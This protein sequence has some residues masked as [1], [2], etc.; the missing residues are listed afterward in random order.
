MLYTCLACAVGFQVPEGQRE[1]Y[2]T[3]WHRY[4]LKRKVAELPAVSAEVFAQK[5]LQQQ[6][7]ARRDK[8]RETLQCECRVCDKVY[9]SHNAYVNHLQSKRH[10]LAELQKHGD[11]DRDSPA[12]S[13]MT[14]STTTQF[15]LGDPLVAGGTQHHDFV[16]M[17][18]LEERV[19]EGRGEGDA[20]SEALEEADIEAEIERRLRET[21]RFEQNECIFC[22]KVHES[23]E[24]DVQ[25]MYKAHGMFIPEQAYLVDLAGL[26]AYLGAKVAVGHTCLFCNRQFKTLLLVRRHMHNKGHCMIKY[27]NEESMLEIG[28]FYDFRSTYPKS[29][30]SN[31]SEWEDDDDDDDDD[32]ESIDSQDLGPIQMDSTSMYLP[33][34]SKTVGHRS[35]LRYYRQTL[36]PP[37]TLPQGFITHQRLMPDDYLAIRPPNTR[38]AGRGPHST[39]S[40]AL[41]IDGGR[42]KA[43]GWRKHLLHLS[44]ERSRRQNAFQLK[45]GM[46][47]NNQKHYRFVFPSAVRNP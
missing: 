30:G 32:D 42:H 16:P 25:H 3:D 40:T 21:R 1:H 11:E 36:R 19:G 8:E 47:H 37:P 22:S 9:A 10:R 28:D 13:L 14:A 23:L 4:N 33:W 31:D 38:V 12:D 2:R 24:V 34:S 15:S 6:D 39:A 44:E 20:R 26:V 43:P 46:Q 18:D 41:T 29:V 27:D 17:Q 35:G 45:V 5:V 7:Q